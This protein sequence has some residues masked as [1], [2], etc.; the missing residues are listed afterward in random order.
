MIRAEVGR[1]A[2]VTASEA[3]QSKTAGDALLGEAAMAH[4]LSRL[5]DRFARDDELIA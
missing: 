3:K 2:G 4:P 1:A 5:L